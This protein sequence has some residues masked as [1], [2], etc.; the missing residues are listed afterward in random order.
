M[1]LYIDIGVTIKTISLF[2]CAAD[3]CSGVSSPIFVVWTRAPRL[4]SISTIFV[5]P[6]FAAQCN[7][8]N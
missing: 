6:P 3:R 1:Y 2:P 7:G 8:E 4:I 5:C